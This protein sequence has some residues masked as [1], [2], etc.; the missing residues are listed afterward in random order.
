MKGS[1]LQ[2]KTILVTRPGGLSNYMRDGICEAGGRALHLP[3]MNISPLVDSLV[4]EQI[5]KS[6]EAFDVLIFVSRNA[7]KYASQHVSDIA[8][9]LTKKPVIALGAGTCEELSRIGL[10]DVI[11]TDGNTG[12]D[13][14]LDMDVLQAD[15]V[16]GKRVLIIR[17]IGGRELLGQRLGERGAE[18]Q[19][20]ELYRRTKPEVA[21]ETIKNMW[22][23]EKPDVVLVTSAE[24]LQNLLELT[25]EKERPL[26]L[27]TRLVVISP[28]V[29]AL[30]ISLGFTAEIKIT[31]GYSDDDF[32]L[33]LIELFGAIE[34]E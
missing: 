4:V 32:L 9:Q 25:E 19:Y 24:G 18:I 5:L 14:V 29:R 26:F 8:R 28:R 11:Y 31:K 12:S 34:N 15:N 17:G 13:A 6:M 2:N 33:A 22:Q 21:A 23:I 7:V 20:A 27:K 30:A 3:S 1:S 16:A 10:D